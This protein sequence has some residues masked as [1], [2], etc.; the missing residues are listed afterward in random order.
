MTAGSY[1]Q[2]YKIANALVL[3]R[4]AACVSIIRNVESTFIW[5]GKIDRSKETLLVI[6][7]K[8]ACFKRLKNQVKKIHS[9]EVPEIIGI[10]IIAGSKEYLDW[11]AENSQN[12]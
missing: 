3:G 6:K 8:E 2:A 4:L 5:K 12:K 1:Q 11:I 9:Y 10:P 7:T